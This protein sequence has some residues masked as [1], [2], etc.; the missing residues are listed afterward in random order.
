MGDNVNGPE[1]HQVIRPERGVD[2][3]DRVLVLTR[4]CRV[5]DGGALGLF[6]L[7]R[8]VEREQSRRQAALL[9]RGDEGGN[10][11]AN[12]SEPFRAVF[13]PGRRG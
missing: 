4:I 1:N 12:F 10:G 5:G 6:H 13:F 7:A 2:R 3:V 9:V 8:G 11:R